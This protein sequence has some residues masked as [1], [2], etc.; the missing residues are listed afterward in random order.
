M[1]QSLVGLCEVTKLLELNDYTLKINNKLL[2]EHTKVSFR[3]GVINHILG[4]NGV[5]KSQFA[6]DLL[7]NRS[8]LIPSEI[9]KNVTII[10]SFSNVP[11]DLKV[12]ELFILLEK[13]FGLDSVAHLAHS[14]HAT[15]ISKTSLIGQL[16]DGQKQKLKLLSFFLE[17]KSIIVLDEITNA[18]DKQTIN[19]IYLF[20][21]A[22]IKNHPKKIILNI[23]HNLSDLKNLKGNYYL[24]EDFKMIRFLIKLKLFRSI[25]R[26]EILELKKTISNKIMIILIAIIV[27]IFAMGWILPIGIDKVTRLSY[28]EYLFSTYTVFTQFGFLMFSFLVSFFINKEYSGKT[29]LFYRMMNTNS[30]TFYIKKVLTLTVETLGSI[31]VLLFIVSFIFMD[32]SVILQMFFLLSMISI[33]YIL[34]VALISFLSAN[35]LLSIGFSILYWITTVLFVAIGGFLRF[36]AIFDASNELYLNVQNFLEGSENSISFDHNLLIILYII[37]LTIIALAIA[38]VNNKRWLR[39]G[40]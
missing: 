12:C 4:K 9:S 29:I 37:V 34:I 14:L 32:F 13:R 35:V 39:L 27:A 31:L 19:E 40:V 21:L 10:S 11:N 15:N 3:K 33:Q 30:L 1:K 22:Y 17:D 5:G 26:G 23:T 7:L 36:F 8:G 20:L 24:I 16:S 25:L 18:L 38:R 28:R 6:M 2:L